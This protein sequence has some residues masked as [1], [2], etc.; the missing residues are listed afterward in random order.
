[1]AKQRD[2]GFGTW[3]TYSKACQRDMDALLRRGGSL[4][5]YRSNPQH[6]IGPARDSWAWRLERSVE[7]TFDVAHAIACNSGTMA[8]QLAIHGA[9]LPAKSEIIV[10]PFSFSAT[11]AA[12]IWAGH[13]PVFADVDYTGCLDPVSVASVRSRRT[14]AILA[15]D[16]FGRV[17]DYPALARNELPMIEDACQALGATRNGRWAGSFGIAAAFSYNGAKNCPAGEAGT[18]VTNDT[19]VATAARLVASHGE[20]WAY[21]EVGLNGRL[22]EPTALIAYHGL[23]DVLARNARRRQLARVLEHELAGL[24]LILPEI[25]GHALYVYPLI[26]PAGQKR[27]TFVERLRSR[28]I[29][30]GEGYITPPLH[31]YPAFAQYRRGRL[32]VVEDLSANR[33]CIFT[34]VRPP[35]TNAAMRYLAR[36]IRAALA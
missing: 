16:L 31:D 5:A 34:Q 28:G 7:Q 32:P 10:T 21:P 26:L 8:L 22:N 13:V 4:S 27:A 24:D 35:A 19:R 23:V 11:V 29:E 3:P 36:E 20:N 1:M 2:V 18:M 6:P 33:L 17:A 9:R 15:V 12:I 14:G 25:D 30:V